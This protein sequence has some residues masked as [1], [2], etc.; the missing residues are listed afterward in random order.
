[1]KYLHTFQTKEDSKNCKLIFPNVCRTTDDD[2]IFINLSNDFADLGLTSG[3]Q[4]MKYNLGAEKETDFG[5]YFQFGDVVGYAGDDAL[6][7]STWSTCP[8]NGG[9]TDFNEDSITSWNNTHTTD[10]ILKGDVDAADFITYGIAKIPTQA[11]LNELISETNTE[12]V[13][14]D[15]IVGRKFIS[16]T[17]ASKYIFIPATGYFLDGTTGGVGIGINIWSS[18]LDTSDLERAYFMNY[19]SGS[20]SVGSGKRSNAFTIRGVLR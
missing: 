20:Y 14:I 4:W 9:N 3:T 1:M 10:S 2:A 13:T 15:G 5:L 7:H 8:G 18:S 11:Q 17:D 19:K 12:W 16:K 6:T